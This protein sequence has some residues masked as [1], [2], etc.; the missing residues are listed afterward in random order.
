MFRPSSTKSLTKVMIVIPVSTGS[1]VG[2][3]SSVKVRVD[4]VSRGV[5]KAVEHD[6]LYFGSTLAC[7]IFQSQ[8]TASHAL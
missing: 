8:C 6:V 4:K 5:S 3:G 7:Q 1:I 2:S